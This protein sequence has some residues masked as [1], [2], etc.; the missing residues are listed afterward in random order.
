[1]QKIFTIILATLV[2][3]A[4]ATIPEIQFDK[5]IVVTTI[6]YPTEA[7]KKM[8]EL[9]GWHLVVVGDKKTPKN[10]HLE[11]CDFLSGERQLELGYEILDLLPW[12]HYSRKNIG[13]LFAIEHGAKLIYETDDDNLAGSIITPKD[14]EGLVELRTDRK[15][16][17]IYAHFGRPDIW[18]RGYPLSEIAFSSHF[19]THPT[20]LHGNIAVIQGLVN[21]EPD[22]DAIYRLTQ[23]AEIYFENS[24]PCILP[25]NTFSP[26]N[27]QNTTFVYDAFWGLYIPSTTPFRV[28]DIWRGYFIQRLLWD[29][30]MFVCFTSPSA[31]QER[32]AHDIFIDFMEEQELYLDAGRLINFLLARE[33]G[34]S[35]IAERYN[36]LMHA[37]ANENFVKQYETKLLE[38]WLNDL[39]KVGYAFPQT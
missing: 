4:Y 18:P 35:T 23:G 25:R 32:N 1:M 38:A 3:I 8:A 6:Q 12:N 19:T 2:H 26:F 33:T 34:E 7:L 22:V 17:N 37:L 28:C 24:S 36:T 13:Y 30:D 29:L 27:T 39:K 16:I 11:N 5:W 15:N 9:P 10:W 21:K 20:N 14:L 31:V